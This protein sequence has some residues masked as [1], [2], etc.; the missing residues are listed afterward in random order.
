MCVEWKMD[1]ILNVLTIEGV[2]REK[3]SGVKGMCLLNELCWCLGL[4]CAVAC[5]CVADCVW[6]L[7]LCVALTSWLN[8]LLCW[9]MHCLFCGLLTLPELCWMWWMTMWWCCWPVM[10]ELCSKY[11]W[12]DL[13][14][15]VAELW[16]N[17]TA[18]LLWMNCLNCCWTELEWCDFVLRCLLVPVNCSLNRLADCWFWLMSV[19][20]L[21]AET[22][23]LNGTDVKPG[24]DELRTVFECT[25]MQ[26]D[27]WLWDFRIWIECWI[28][29]AAV[30]CCA[31]CAALW[32]RPVDELTCA[33]TD[34]D[35]LL[36][37]WC[38]MCWCCELKLWTLVWLW[39]VHWPWHVLMNLAVNWLWLL[40]L[41]GSLLCWMRMN[42]W[43]C[44]GSGWIVW[45]ECECCAYAADCW[46]DERACCDESMICDVLPC[47][48]D[49]LVDD[50]AG[51]HCVLWSCWCCWTVCLCVGSSCAV[52]DAIELVELCW[53]CCVKTDWLDL[54]CWCWMLGCLWCW[55]CW[56]SCRCF[57]WMLLCV[58]VVHVTECCC[59][60]CC[61]T[62][63]A[64]LC[65][66]CD[67]V[68][69]CVDCVADELCRLLMTLLERLLLMMCVADGWMNPDLSCVDV[70][71]T[72]IC[73]RC[74]LACE[75][76]LTCL[77]W[78]LWTWPVCADM[79]WCW[80]VMNWWK[81]NYLW[82]MMSGM[83]L[84]WCCWSLTVCCW[85]VD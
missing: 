16:M 13:V 66:L 81:L 72:E 53:N 11:F 14:N 26:C 35:L 49:V 17:L 62:G 8:V 38:M 78:N 84:T 73:L 28:C 39:N 61:W 79:R 52:N 6:L 69:E 85:N 44:C 83:L 68:D 24:C 57:W 42:C 70:K 55:T 47:M 46:C 10:N 22:R 64:V 21:A 76:D 60:D 12:L 43:S 20:V 3:G 54:N 75:A 27:C 1:G 33:V 40:V 23:V 30:C 80:I 41:R 15:T 5:W 4:C 2:V 82:L 67:A 65:P 51:P 25:V 7:T 56:R 31:L 29:C 36:L 45:C 74:L 48:M 19:L 63:I 37:C 50:C 34:S 18:E 71:L 58:P 32:K 59:D 77:L 9:N